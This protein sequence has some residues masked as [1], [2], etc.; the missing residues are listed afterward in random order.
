MS[1]RI[2]FVGNFLIDR[3][4][5]IE[6]PET[7]WSTECQVAW[8][9]EAM[10]H[11]VARCQ[12]DDP[13]V[14]WAA[15]VDLAKEWNADLVLWVQTWPGIDPPG[16][17][18]A[19]DEFGRAGIPTVSFHL[20]LYWGLGR[21]PQ[22]LEAPFWRTDWVFTADGGHQDEF[23]RAGIN[24]VWSP[25]AVFEPDA[26]YRGAPREEW[27]RWPIVFLGSYPYPHPQHAPA[28]AEIVN[29]VGSYFRPRFRLYK[30]GIRRRDLCDF[31][32]SVKVIVG[33]SCLAGRAPRYWS[34]RI[35]EILGRGGFLIHP[36]VDGIEDHYTDGV[37]L[38]LFEAGDMGQLLS[39][40]RHH[41]DTP[42]GQAEA[43]QIGAQGR[44]HVLGAHT[45]RHRLEALLATV[46]LSEEVPA[47]A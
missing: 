13:D 38:R 1:L 34:D 2:V 28:R 26:V 4:P 32:A 14:G 39:I 25:P 6:P 35:P 20:D 22:L 16:A 29:Q 36:Y 31:V 37:H 46:G 47:D 40:C 23:A 24:H 9:L 18:R 43:A 10:G 33:D 27:Q 41:L 12:E 3:H 30:S 44:R 21:A 11:R 7:R 8:T 5:P 19:L 45:Y 17:F 15:R 42:E